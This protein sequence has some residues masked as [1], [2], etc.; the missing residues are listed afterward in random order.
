LQGGCSFCLGLLERRFVFIERRFVFLGRFA[1]EKVDFAWKEI[2]FEKKGFG[3]AWEDL[4]GCLGGS[5][6][7]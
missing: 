4:L 1:E 5:F 7:M 6:S 3:V 2:H